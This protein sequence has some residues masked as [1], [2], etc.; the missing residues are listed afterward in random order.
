MKISWPHFDAEAELL[1]TEGLSTSPNNWTADDLD[2]NGILDSWE[3]ALVAALLTDVTQPRH[4]EV[5]C[6]LPAQLGRERSL[7]DYARYSPACGTTSSPALAC[8]SAGGQAAMA[9]EGVEA[10]FILL[11]DD[12]L[13]NLGDIDEDGVSNIEEFWAIARVGGDRDAFVAARAGSRRGC[14]GNSARGRVDR[15]GTQFYPPTTR[16]SVP[17]HIAGSST[18]AMV[19]IDNDSNEARVVTAIE[20]VSDGTF[21]LSGLPPCRRCWP[22]A[23]PFSFDVEFSPSASGYSQMAL[24]VRTDNNV[25][26]ITIGV[27][28]LSN[29]GGFVSCPILD[30]FD[31]EG[32]GWSGSWATDDEDGG[33]VPDSWEVALVAEVLC[34]S[35]HARAR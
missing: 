32:D 4:A 17:Q 25:H 11:A 13:A 23:H 35:A 1:Y 28:G 3:T 29:T 7:L 15:H 26:P 21:V 12:A 34:D 22:P 2:D 9:E 18:S 33:G 8:L 14:P 19:M 20:W 27:S 10:D 16:R 24:T 31:A 5:M 30:T 6:N